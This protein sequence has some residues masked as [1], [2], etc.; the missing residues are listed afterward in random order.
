ME[1][2]ECATQEELRQVV[3]AGNGAIVRNGYFVMGGSAS[4]RA[5][6]SAS[7]R[8]FD[9]A[10]VRAFDSASVEAFGSASVRA[11]GSASVEAFG[12]ASVRASG[13][14]SVEAFGSASVEAFGSA[15]VEASGSASVRA[16][17]SASVRA[18]DSASVRAFDSASVHLFARALARI[19][20][21]DVT[22]H[23]QDW[24]TVILHAAA[25]VALTAS[26][27]VIDRVIRSAED[28]ASAYGAKRREDGCLVLRK[29]VYADGKSGY[30]TLYVAG[31]SVSAE[32]WDDDPDRECGGGLHACAS[33]L[34]ATKYKPAGEA[35]AVELWVDPM[36][37][38]VPLPTDEMPEKIRFRTAYVARVWNPAED[39]GE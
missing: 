28:W 22:V 19:M 13:S 31:Q 33:L 38:R 23:A 8:A 36:D 7:V 29:W 24:A 17:G 16:S 39:K 30:G 12:S 27:I 9:S 11:F 2:I 25:D 14:A 21:H 6:G 35:L 37:C 34:D 3:K 1:W 5:S 18:F 26:V 10:S 15:S 32:D 20:S 4:V